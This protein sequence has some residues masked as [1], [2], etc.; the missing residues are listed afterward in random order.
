[1]VQVESSD[2]AY[3]R[4][5]PDTSPGACPGSTKVPALVRLRADGDGSDAVQ[6][7]RRPMHIALSLAKPG[8]SG[9]SR[10]LLILLHLPS[11]CRPLRF[12]LVQI[13]A[14]GRPG[15]STSSGARP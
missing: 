6:S 3:L 8:Q 4:A 9:A 15:T 11:A 13:E 14:S 7:G 2:Y 5:L 1:M 10:R 12:K